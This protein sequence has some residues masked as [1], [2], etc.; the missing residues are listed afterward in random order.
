MRWLLVAVLLMPVQQTG[1]KKAANPYQ[2]TQPIKQ[3]QATPSAPALPT[4]IDKGQTASAQN[5]ADS[6][7]QKNSGL[8]ER[9]LD[10]LIANWPLVLV[11]IGG[12]WAALATLRVIQRQIDLQ[13]RE[14]IATHRPKLVI[15]EVRM[16]PRTT[17]PNVTISY[18]VSNA[19]SGQAQIVESII[20]VQRDET[21]VIRQLPKTKQGFNEW[22]NN[23]HAL[24][25]IDAGTFIE[26]THYSEVTHQSFINQICRVNAPA[27]PRL[28]FRGRL[29][30]EDRNK[31]RWQMAFCRSYDFKSARFLRLG[32]PDYEYED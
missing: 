12:I 27:L 20:E 14:F 7:R 16:L 13:D 15:R 8:W 30:Y 25:P 11:G 3:N 24:F 22:G 29:I 32:D 6:K 31:T 9:L 28:L 23:V 4:V 1:S 19:G 5:Q 21:G 26:C 17:N 10:A 18:I 2:H